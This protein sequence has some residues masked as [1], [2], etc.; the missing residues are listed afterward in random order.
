MAETQERSNGFALA[1]VVEGGLALVAVLLAWLF[2]V[3]LREQIPATG[4]LLAYAVTRGVL[5]TLPMLAV[6]LWL[7]HSSWTQIRE[8]RRQVEWLIAEMF[9]EASAAQ[10]ALIA[11]LAGV[12]EE[13]LFR[14]VLQ[15][16]I[17]QWTTPMVGLCITSLLFGLVHALSKLY[18]F[19]ATAIGLCFGALVLQ[20]NDLV[21]PMVAHSL[22]DFFA[23]TYLSRRLRLSGDSAPPPELP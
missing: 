11:V 10:F 20:Y 12:G 6:F 19:L 8:L 2:H 13:L 17:G 21:A 9:S 3:P 15:S 18:F 16:L 22:Y 4:E 23:L 7:V 1:V 5:V 14:G